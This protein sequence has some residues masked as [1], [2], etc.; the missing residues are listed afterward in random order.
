MIAIAL[1]AALV[2]G[3]QAPSAP[4]DAWFQGEHFTGDWGGAR[5]LLADHG[6]TIDAIYSAELFANATALAHQERALTMLG[7]LDLA[8]TLDTGKLGLWPG[9][10]FYAL[11]QNNHGD[12]IN[13]VTGSANVIS[14]LETGAP[15]TQLTELF[16]EQALFGERLKFRVGKQDANREFGTPRY[17]GN[18]LNDS[19]GMYP[20]SPLPSYPSTGLGA[21][22]IGQPLEWL[23]VRAGLYEGS[24]VAG[25][26]LDSAFKPGAGFAVV[27]GLAVSHRYGADHRN[28]GVTSVGVWYQSVELPELTDVAPPRTFGSDVGVLVQNDER[29]YSSPSNPD[30]PGGLNIITRFAWS[31]P[32]RTPIALYAGGSVAWHGLGELRHDDTVGLGFGYFSVAQQLN[33]HLGPG[34][35]YFVEAFYKLR[36]TRF[37]S[38]QP[39]LELYRHPGGDGRDAVLAGMRLKAKL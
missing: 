7:H 26:G 19:F 22:V 3:Q 12:G 37:L 18:F 30:D 24:P 29:I 21:V 20:T 33:G 23:S 35:E 38:L 5:S 4:E 16:F 25:S 15:Y 32:D 8:L 28:G 34:A 9:G 27:G 11:G 2:L 39:D 31:Q 17:G 13:E 36:L 6:L 14:N 10:K 1:A